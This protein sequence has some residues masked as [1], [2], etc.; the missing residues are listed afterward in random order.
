MFAGPI[1]GIPNADDEIVPSTEEI[2][3]AH[4][5]R[6]YPHTLGGG[7]FSGYTVFNSNVMNG[8]FTR[9]GATTP[10]LDHTYVTE[11]VC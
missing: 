7:V 2:L 4:F 5:K 6:H 1:V 3:A 8:H 10:Q 9:P 11:W